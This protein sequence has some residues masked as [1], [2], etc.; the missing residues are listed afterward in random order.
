MS[1]DRDEDTTPPESAWNRAWEAIA[2]EDHCEIDQQLVAA[3]AEGRLTEPLRSRVLEAISRSPRAVKILDELTTELRTEN[4]ADSPSP[5]PL[6]KNQAIDRRRVV[7]Q[8]IAA[9]S[10]LVAT[11]AAI[12]AVA[13]SRSSADL[14]AALEDSRAKLNSQN[15]ELDLLRADQTRL[16][17]LLESSELSLLAAL[18]DNLAELTKST[19]PSMNGSAGLGTIQL[20]LADSRSRGIEQ[21]PPEV[22][23]LA[24]KMT[25]ETLKRASALR[26]AADPIEKAS[27][28]LSVGNFDAAM[29]TLAQSSEIVRSGAAGLNLQ[30]CVLMARADKQPIAEAKT[31]LAAADR[32]LRSAADKD[33]TY[34]PAWFNLALIQERLDDGEGA[35]VAWREY[36]NRELRPEFR[37]AVRA[38]RGLE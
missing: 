26:P 6:I 15:N 32:M 13:K 34:A 10:I 12:W 28:E 29:E 5:H 16:A 31:T 30:A 1:T 36:L 35:I 24:D 21:L 17:A 14:T 18:K 8:W 33:P 19:R 7:A 38:A 11:G 20:A 22:Q 37:E 27:L 23:R 2:E 3:Y 9:A 25:A 4:R